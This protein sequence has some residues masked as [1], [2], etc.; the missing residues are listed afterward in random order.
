M[1]LPGAQ[2]IGYHP[3]EQFVRCYRLK[4]VPS[5]TVCSPVGA[6]RTHLGRSYCWVCR[7]RWLLQNATV[8]SNVPVLGEALNLLPCPLNFRKILI[9]SIRSA[10]THASGTD[11]MEGFPLDFHIAVW[12]ALRL[13]SCSQSSPGC[14]RPSRNLHLGEV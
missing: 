14:R 10:L 4:P 2:K 12:L 11:R 3:Q 6:Q 5:T 1:V 7:D 9:E 8:M 13:L